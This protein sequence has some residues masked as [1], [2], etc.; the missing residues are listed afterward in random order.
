MQQNADLRELK[1]MNDEQVVELL[2]LCGA[3]SEDRRCLV[4]A[5]QKLRIY[6]GKASALRVIAPN[7]M[8]WP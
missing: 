4:T 7:E 5:L 6:S 8:L 3:D 2:N 1:T